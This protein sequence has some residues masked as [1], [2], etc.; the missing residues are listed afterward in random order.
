MRGGN[1]SVDNRVSC[2][3]LCKKKENNI[4]KQ[5]EMSHNDIFSVEA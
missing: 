4:R 5:E 3:R 2:R 1:F